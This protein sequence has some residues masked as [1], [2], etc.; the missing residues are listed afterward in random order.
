M[1]AAS[2]EECR[3]LGGENPEERKRTLAKLFTGHRD[4]LEA[5]PGIRGNE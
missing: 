5:K 1:A 4:R 3:R 2:D